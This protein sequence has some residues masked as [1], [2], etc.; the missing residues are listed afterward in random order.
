MLK[1]VTSPPHSSS[2]SICS[3]STETMLNFMMSSGG[4]ISRDVTLSFPFSLSYILIAVITF[5]V[6]FKNLGACILGV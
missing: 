3:R 5:Y 6:I 2:G 4:A 1:G